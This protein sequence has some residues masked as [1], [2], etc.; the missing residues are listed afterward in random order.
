[1]SRLNRRN[2][3]Q[4]HVGDV[5][6]LGGWVPDPDTGELVAYRLK[7]VFEDLLRRRD[8]AHRRRSLGGAEVAE[9]QRLGLCEHVRH[10]QVERCDVHQRCRR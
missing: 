5:G 7:R 2:V 10:Q 1:M 4:G 6:F 3:L 9:R 8:A